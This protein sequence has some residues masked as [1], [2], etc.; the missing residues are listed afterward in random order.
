MTPSASTPLSD[1]VLKEKVTATL[2]EGVEVVRLVKSLAPDRAYEAKLSKP[3]HS[4]VFV[5][6]YT[7]EVKGSHERLPFFQT[8][9]RLHLWLL[10]SKPANGGIYWASCVW[11]S[12]HCFSFSSCGQVFSASG[13]ATA[14]I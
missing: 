2:L 7:G 6:P 8:M 4:S 13:H 1:D 3:R 10:D 9:F 12:V 11:A 5:D 14:R